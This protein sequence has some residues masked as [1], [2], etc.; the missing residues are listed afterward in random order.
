MALLEM[1]QICKAFSGVY[2]ND[3]VDLMV[4]KGEIHA[5]LGENGAGKTTLMNILFGIYSA[6]SGQILWKGEPVRFASPKDAIAAGIGMVQQHFSLVRKMTVLDNIILNLRDNRFVLDRKQARQR[7]C[8]LAEK[9]GL[10]VDPDAQ[11]GSLSVGEQQRVEILKALYRDVELLILDEPTGVL[12][13]QETAQFFEVLRAL[14]KEGYGI[15]I[16]THR[17]SEIMAISDRVTILRDGKK[18]AS[19]SRPRPSPMSCP[20]T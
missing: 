7:V 4:E 18:V 5:L 16:I 2:A 12:T 13:P 17:M 8:A 15:I 14:Q 10:T 1:Q 19:W 20:G 6:D 11:V 3:H 9:Y